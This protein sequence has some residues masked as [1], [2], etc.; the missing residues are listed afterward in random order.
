MEPIRPAR[1]WTDVESAELA[2]LYHLARTALAGCPDQSTYQ[3]RLWAAKQ[4]NR[5]HPDVEVTSAYKELDRQAAW[6]Y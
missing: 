5:L 2:N 1:V 4:Y 6:R 3:R